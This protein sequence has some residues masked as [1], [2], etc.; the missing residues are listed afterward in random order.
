[1]QHKMRRTGNNTTGHHGLELRPRFQ[2][3]HRTVRAMSHIVGWR[4]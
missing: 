2:A 1:M 4:G 3:Q